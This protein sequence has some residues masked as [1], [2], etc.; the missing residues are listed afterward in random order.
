MFAP[1]FRNRLD[2]V[3][4]FGICR[5]TSIIKVVDKFIMQ[6][7]AQL[8]DRNVT[9]ELDRRS[10]RWLVE[11][12]YDEQMGARPMARV[13]QQTIK[14]P[15]ADEVLFGRL[16]NGGA[17]RVVVRRGGWREEARLRLP[18]RPGPAAS[19][20]R[21]SSRPARN[22]LAEPE[23]RRAKARRLKGSEGDG[24]GEDDEPFGDD[25]EPEPFGTADEVGHEALTF[26]ASERSRKKAVA[27]PRPFSLRRSRSGG[28]Q[29][30]DDPLPKGRQRLGLLH[31]AA[32]RSQRHAG[33]ARHNMEMQVE[34]RLAAG[35]LVELQ[36]GQAVGVEGAS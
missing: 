29:S 23:V 14:T 25:D 33:P 34:D 5:V 7:E 9:I 36:D 18:R 16:K 19:R 1:E 4:T 32:M 8:A 2:A 31:D 22:A 21:Q 24:E 11:H 26:A 28:G 12:G 10:A 30:G 13:I 17:V 27:T 15:L 35:G 20:A 3:V 6:L